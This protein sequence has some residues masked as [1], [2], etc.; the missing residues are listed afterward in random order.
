MIIDTDVI[1]DYLRGQKDAVDFLEEHVE[2]THLSAMSVAELYQGVREGKERRQLDAMLEAFTLL[3]IDSE[4]ATA[5]G[6][7]RRDYRNKFGCGLADCIIAASA[8]HHE[9]PLVTLNEKH[10][11]MIKDVMIP[12][13]K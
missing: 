10:F 6:L 7:L 11:G 12:Y 9:L 5:A 8:L 1:I 4:I 13:Q 3:P 2:D